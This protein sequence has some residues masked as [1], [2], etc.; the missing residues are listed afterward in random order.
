MQI[1][2]AVAQKNAT[3]FS[4]ATLDHLVSTFQAEIT[5]GVMAGAVVPIGIRARNCVRRISMF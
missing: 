5:A 2:P 1:T 4:I 3:K